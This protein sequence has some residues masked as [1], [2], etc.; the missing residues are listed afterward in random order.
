MFSLGNDKQQQ[1]QSVDNMGLRI[2][3]SLAV[4]KLNFHRLVFQDSLLWQQL[5]I[6]SGEKKS[7]CDY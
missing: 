6:K 3:S 7:A 1:Q 5:S 4:S 2:Y